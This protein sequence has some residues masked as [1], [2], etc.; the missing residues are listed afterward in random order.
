MNDR[1]R[2][3][4]ECMVRLVQEWKEYGSLI[5]AYDFDNT[6]FD[7]HK[8]G[9]TFDSVIQ[10]LRKCASLGFHLVVFTSCDEDRYDE[11]RKYLK[12]N[13]IPFDGIN[14]TPEFIPFKGRKVYYNILLD[15]RA[16]LNDA[17]K[18][19]NALFLHIESQSIEMELSNM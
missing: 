16:G 19:L 10:I 11:I 2:D 6:V 14:E 17:C 13:D 8:R 15:D 18:M 4:K 12:D 7:Y 1:Y 3:F 5:V 9:D